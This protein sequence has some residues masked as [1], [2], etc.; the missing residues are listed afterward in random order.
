VPVLARPGFDEFEHVFEGWLIEE[1]PDADE[2][3]KVPA[4]G[5][6]PQDGALPEG[7]IETRGATPSPGGAS[8]PDG[9]RELNG[10]ATSLPPTVAPAPALPPAA[11]P[12]P[13]LPPTAVLAPAILPA[14]AP[15]SALPPA[16]APAPALP[17]AAA[18]TPTLASAAPDVA[19]SGGPASDLAAP[20]GAS[21][22]PARVGVSASPAPADS[23]PINL[24]DPIVSGGLPN[25]DGAQHAAIALVAPSVL[26]SARAS[27]TASASATRLAK[28]DRRTHLNNR[29]AHTLQRDQHMA[30]LLAGRKMAPL[31]KVVRRGK[32][33]ALKHNALADG[34]PD[35]AP[36]DAGYADAIK[37]KVEAVD[38]NLGNIF[39]S[40]HA[41]LWEA[42][43]PAW[44]AQIL[45]TL[46]AAADPVPEEELKDLTAVLDEF[47]YQNGYK[48]DLRLHHR[49]PANKCPSA[50]TK[51]MTAGRGDRTGIVV[52]GIAS[53][54]EFGDELSEWWAA[55]QPDWRPAYTQLDTEDRDWGALAY[56]G[57]NGIL[58]FVRAM[59][60]WVCA[61]PYDYRV[62][63]FSGDV[64]WVLGAMC[65]ALP[66]LQVPP[67]NPDALSEDDKAHTSESEL[68]A[69][70]G[71]MSRDKK[72]TKAGRTC[73]PRDGDVIDLSDDE[74]GKRPVRAAVHKRVL[75]HARCQPKSAGLLVSL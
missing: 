29:S 6:V 16:A 30:M 25:V 33:S 72:P 60:W 57:P 14:A 1:F 36:A 47:E 27:A 65:D 51:W 37:A 34:T 43:T 42:E 7:A 12:A 54:D 52:P 32:N 3:E 11:A 67:P 49:L 55:L 5:A 58:L 69:S 56:A 61:N 64:I 74:P 31:G 70:D 39:D 4:D 68:E 2:V 22:S 63:A 59:S 66:E 45:D 48:S 41:P 18:P 50:V 53:P 38:R 17:P 13:T 46:R 19:T 71:G 35:E 10:A 62:D 24:P 28:L 73:K 21:A 26:R 15:A 40:E 75:K 20:V 44:L 23:M 8:S 9:A